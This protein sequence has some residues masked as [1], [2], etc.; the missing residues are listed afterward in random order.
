MSHSSPNLIFFFNGT[1]TTEIYTSFPTRRS[2]D[3]VRRRGAPLAEVL[4]RMR[5]A[6]QGRVVA[7]DEGA[8]QGGANALVGLCAGD[9]YA[10]DAAFGEDGLEVGGLEG[11]AVALRDE[12][13]AVAALQLGHVLPRLTPLRQRLVVGV[14]HPHDRHL[15]G[16]GA[17]HEGR[18]G[19][20]GGVAVDRV[21][22]DAVLHV[23]DHEGG[24]RTVS[25]GRHPANVST[26]ADTPTD[27]RRSA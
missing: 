24:M 14:L 9:D 22:H 18:D 3:L 10:P 7:A 2:S 27:G 25:E 6:H 15:L 12:G 5:V 21:G 20:D 23:D 16:A 26:S 19:R 4:R 17:V 8:V 11:V 1:A 13:L